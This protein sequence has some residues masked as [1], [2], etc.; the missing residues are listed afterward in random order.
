MNVL[1]LSKY[2]RIGASSRLRSYQ[3]IPHL[4]SNG[5]NI[6]ASPLFDDEY[7][8]GIYSG[9][10][11]IPSIMSNYFKRLTT[12][13]H[14][15]KFDL[16]WV[17]KEVFPWLPSWFEK[18]FLPKL[19]L[20]VDYD[21]A[22]F[23]RY[24]QHKFRLVRNLMGQKID[25]I[26][27]RADVVIVG[28]NYLADR[29]K[30]AG[31]RYVEHIPTVIDINRYETTSDRNE[32]QVTI[33]WI[34]TPWSMQYLNKISHVIRSLTSTKKVR[35]VAVGANTEL[36]KDIPAEIRPWTEETE[37]AEIMQFDIGIMPI[38]DEPFERGKC[39]YKL[40]QYM[41]CGLPV[42]AS[43][44]GANSSVVRSGVDGFLA[45]NDNQWMT[46]LEKL[47]E[48]KNL[49]VKMGNAGRE[50]VEKNFTLQITAPKLANIFQKLT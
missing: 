27:Q 45:D 38:P 42:I 36:I 47:C 31:A 33:G 29:A 49:R 17:E 8:T 14:A 4:E 43:P 50:R 16:I 5:I 25:R 2:S 46:A 24:D 26:M 30:S 18:I 13:I 32:S 7:I 21:D 40:I 22:I 19:P 20:I 41:A 10:K 39:A 1:L 35:F 9:N 37:V 15:Q 44:V 11:N 48:N 3:Y 12:I 34:G 6:T 28:N 23:H